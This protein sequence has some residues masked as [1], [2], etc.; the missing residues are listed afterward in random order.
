MVLLGVLDNTADDADV[1]DA[2][3]ERRATPD[4]D[5]P[6]AYVARAMNMAVVRAARRG[7][8]RGVAADDD[9]AH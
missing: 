4:A 3:V 8:R 6:G 5:A 2:V 9:S 7:A 1:D